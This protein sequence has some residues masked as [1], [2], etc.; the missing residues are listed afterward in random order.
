M[1]KYIVT[2]T[3]R[4]SADPEEIQTGE[5][6]ARDEQDARGIYNECDVISVTP[7]PL[8]PADEI[9]QTH[10]NRVISMDINHEPCPACI[11]KATCKTICQ[12]RKNYNLK[13]RDPRTLAQIEMDL[14]ADDWKRQV[15]ELRGGI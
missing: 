14:C 12:V 15:A 4:Y 1:N 6:L 8:E 3:S 2:F 13:N 7:A 11:A 10:L 5:T 9:P